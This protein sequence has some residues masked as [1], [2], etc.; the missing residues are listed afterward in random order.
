MFPTRTYVAAI[1]A[2]ALLCAGPASGQPPRHQ[3]RL[4]ALQQQ[5]AFLQQQNAVQ[6]A[7]QQATAALQAANSA[8]QQAGTP[9]TII[10][11]QQQTVL[12]IAIQQTTALLQSSYRQNS[13]LGQLAL[14]ELNTLQ[15]T[16]T[17]RVLARRV[18]IAGRKADDVSGATAITGANRPVGAIDLSAPASVRSK[19]SQVVV[20]WLSHGGQYTLSTNGCPAS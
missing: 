3:R 16:A 8:S 9:N 11:Q 20:C 6:V 7:V 15:A 10:L 12:Q 14:R 1:I 19:A 4:V 18:A 17:D 5:N 13:G 2:G